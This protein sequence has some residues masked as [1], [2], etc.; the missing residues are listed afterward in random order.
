MV[1]YNLRVDTHVRIHVHAI[2]QITHDLR[3]TG[4]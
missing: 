1:E 2:L 3:D 4:F